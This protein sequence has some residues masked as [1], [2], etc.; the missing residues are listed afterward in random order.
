[1]SS[2]VKLMSHDFSGFYSY[3]TTIS[4]GLSAKPVVEEAL[5]NGLDVNTESVDIPV[6]IHRAELMVRDMS[7]T[8]LG[9]GSEFPGVQG[10]R[11]V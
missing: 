10:F 2:H 8:L 7:S 4:A 9:S 11:G 3:A 1:M 5:V 6:Y